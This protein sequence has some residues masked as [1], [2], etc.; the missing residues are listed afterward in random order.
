MSHPSPPPQHFDAYAEDYDAALQ[1]GLRVTGE[2]KEYYAQGRV[3]FLRQV[4][5][6]SALPV[7]SILDFGCGVGSATPYL[8]RAFSPQLIEG[9][10]VSPKS[11]EVATRQHGSD[12]VRFR[13]LG[14]SPSG[15]FDLAFV[16]GV[17]HHIPPA[18]RDQ[19][20]GWIFRALRPG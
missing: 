7:R 14:D 6:S 9:V 2:G 19:A 4:L 1:Q 18:D 12:R 3:D 5:P 15:E 11:I 16:N 17:F 20:L 13:L 10:D 8:L